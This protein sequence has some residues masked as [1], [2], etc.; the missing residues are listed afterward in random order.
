MTIVQTTNMRI[1]APKKWHIHLTVPPG[2][3][4]VIQEAAVWGFIYGKSDRE[5]RG[6]S[7]ATAYG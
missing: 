4:T 5:L 1:E 3:L 7:I 6:R 2:S